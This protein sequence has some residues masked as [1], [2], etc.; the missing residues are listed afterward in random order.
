MG[1][2]S[3]ER[4]TGCWT[5][6]PKTNSPK[7]Q[8]TQALYQLTQNNWSTHPKKLVNSPKYFGQL[9]QVFG[10]LTQ[11]FF[12]I[13]VLRNVLENYSTYFHYVKNMFSGK[14]AVLYEAIMRVLC[15]FSKSSYNR[16]L[17]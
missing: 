7:N 4:K 10:Q 9:T 11:V 1:W 3:A 2:V 14:L 5:T 12:K 6:H 8:L 16:V 13:C 15:F 17:N